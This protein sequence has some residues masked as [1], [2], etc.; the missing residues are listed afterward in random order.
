VR[1]SY[2]KALPVLAGGLMLQIAGGEPALARPDQPGA[3]DGGLETWIVRLTEPSLARYRGGL[4]GLEPTHARTLGRRELDPRSPASRAYLRFLD[5]RHDQIRA[6]IEGRC[7]RAVPVMRRFRAAVNGLAVRLSESEAGLVR[8]VPGVRDVVRDVADAPSTDRGPLFIR[9][10]EIWPGG[11]TGADTMGEGVVIGILD[12]GINGS[13]PSFADPG[14]VDDHA[15]TNPLGSGVFL[16]RC[17]LAWWHSRYYPHCN[18]KLIGAYS[19]STDNDPE[20][21]SGH[22][23]H[24]SSTAAGNLL[25][26]LVPVVNTVNSSFRYDI[27]GVAPHANLVMY[28][29]C[30]PD[31]VLC[32][33]SAR[34]AAVDQAILDGVIDVLNHSIEMGGSPWTNLVSEAFFDAT[35]AGIFVAQSAGNDGPMS[36]TVASGTAP[37]TASVA[38]Q[39]HD[40]VHSNTLTSLTANGGLADIIGFSRSAGTSGAFEIVYAGDQDVGGQTFPLCADGPSVFPPDGSST[41]FPAGLFTGKIVICDRG[42]YARVEKGFNVAQAGAAGYILANDA[43]T[44]DSLDADDHYLPATHI[45]HT[46]GVALKAWLGA[47]GPTFT[48]EITD[49]APAGNPAFGDV[50]RFS[51]SRGPHPNAPEVI[52]PDLS[53]PGTSILA[54][55]RSGSGGDEVG[56][57]GGT[58]MASPHV[59][60]AAALLR[61]VHPTWSPAEIKSALMLTAKAVVLKGDGITPGDP[62][63]QGSGRVH[64]GGAARALLVMDETS[65]NFQ[66]AD[67]ATGGDPTNL[68]LASL[69]DPGCNE[70]CSWSRTFRNVSGGPVEFDVVQSA[71]APD[72]ILTSDVTNFTLAEGASQ[73]VQFTAAVSSCPPGGCG[74]WMFGEFGL[75]V[76]SSPLGSDSDLDLHVPVAIIPLPEPGPLVGLCSGVA[77][78]MALAR[79]RAAREQRRNGAR[80]FGAGGRRRGAVAAGW[81]GL[82]RHQSDMDRLGC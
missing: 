67:P 64:V 59:A 71:G 43:S 37:W 56:F 60:G 47:G 61:A 42:T 20:D 63:D 40:R 68:N 4:A 82:V 17:A 36:A 14:P 18:D 21:E 58:S 1:W 66:A 10:D 73:V 76:Y 74:D 33:T 34:I 12:T 25:T 48:G 19:F 65:T 55:V 22:G 79:L 53:A 62:F 7:G 31:P 13:H 15:Y 51:S 72:L 35:E 80:S 69:A 46:D 3:D 29:V 52:K 27:S 28:E 23:S 41:P 16:G 2:L 81:R 77:L 32:S 45:T 6:S 8:G 9:A 24:V 50:L 70:T 11:F 57:Y 38:N 44:G 39:S 30:A 54:A 26:V 49:A 75:Q 78:L 5:R